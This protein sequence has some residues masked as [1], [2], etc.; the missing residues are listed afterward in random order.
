MAA[1]LLRL[2]ALAIVTLHAGTAASAGPVNVGETRRS[3]SGEEL[4]R[5]VASP[6]PPALTA[7]VCRS[8]ASL[9]QAVSR[10]R[11]GVVDDQRS[12]LARRSQAEG[13]RGGLVPNP[14]HHARP[15]SS[16]AV[17]SE[18]HSLERHKRPG[19]VCTTSPA[20]AHT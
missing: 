19:N 4:V 12:L 7:L 10:L 17:G 2:V 13:L 6:P 14:Q 1:L 18:T 8:E 15:R 11:G 9:C 5:T 20:K 3:L 16:C